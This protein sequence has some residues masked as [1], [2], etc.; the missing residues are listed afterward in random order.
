MLLRL[1]KP[2]R[3]YLKHLLIKQK[4]VISNNEKHEILKMFLCRNTS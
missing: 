4:K 1:S 2:G 3:P